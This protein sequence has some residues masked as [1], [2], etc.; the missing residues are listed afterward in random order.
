MGY[1]YNPYFPIR[2]DRTW[3]YNILA[4]DTSETYAITYKDISQDTFTTV[5]TF[6]TLTSEVRW[7]CGPEGLL[8]NEYANFNLPEQENISFETIELSGVFLPPV[9][10]WQVGYTWQTSYKVKL[11]TTVEG[12]TVEAEAEVILDHV[13]SAYEEVSVAAG[14]FPQ[15]ARVDTNGVMNLSFFGETTEIPLVYSDWYARDV[16]LVKSGSESAENMLTYYTELV[17]FE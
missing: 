4:E 9:E 10:Q 12:F 6:S 17:S 3:T 13:L 7:N 2:D 8:S 1:C 5:Q 11:N 14:T 16:G 15:A